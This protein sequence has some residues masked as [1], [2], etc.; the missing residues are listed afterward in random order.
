MWALIL[1]LAAS[2]SAA[3]SPLREKIRIPGSARLIEETKTRF[4]E[5]IL[6]GGESFAASAARTLASPDAFAAPPA[7]PSPAL[8]ALPAGL[9]PAASG[10][11]DFF[12]TRFLSRLNPEAY[13]N[14][15]ARALGSGR[16]DEGPGAP[17]LE[18]LARLPAG[19]AAAAPTTR[20]AS[21]ASFSSAGS[22]GRGFDSTRMVRGRGNGGGGLRPRLKAR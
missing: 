17:N 9:Q 12:S 10:L 15:A 1:L 18:D 21:P 2:A 8:P 19:G 20:L 22:V 4:I 7:D 11:L 14:A 13:A 6:G 16:Q 5:P 3:E